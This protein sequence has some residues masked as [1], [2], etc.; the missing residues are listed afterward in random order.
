MARAAVTVMGA[1]TR[2]VPA[3]EGLGGGWVVVVVTGMAQRAAVFIAPRA[4]G[5]AR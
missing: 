3:R 1:L 2:G 5:A 4:R